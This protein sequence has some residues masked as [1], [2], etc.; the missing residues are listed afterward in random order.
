MIKLESDFT[1]L[2][3]YFEPFKDAMNFKLGADIIETDVLGSDDD[4]VIDE[5]LE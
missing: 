3:D 4:D 2:V 1:Q 5:E